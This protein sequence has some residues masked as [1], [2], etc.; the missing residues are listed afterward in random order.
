MSAQWMAC[1]LPCACEYSRSN[2][3]VASPRCANS[4]AS[5][6]AFARACSFIWHLQSFLSS[7][8]S[9]P[10]VHESGPSTLGTAS[11]LLPLRLPRDSTIPG[12]HSIHD[13][14]SKS[15]GGTCL[16]LTTTRFCVERR[17]S[18]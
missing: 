12:H 7:H 2:Q 15:R 9:I 1:S 18:G 8:L 6:R 3:P 17:A 10:I 4:W 11:S 16:H 13:R 5:C 14:E